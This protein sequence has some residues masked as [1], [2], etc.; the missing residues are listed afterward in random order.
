MKKFRKQNLHIHRFK[1]PSFN[2][3]IIHTNLPSN[4]SGQ[5]TE[6]FYSLSR[7]DRSSLLID[8]HQTPTPNSRRNERDQ[9]PTPQSKR[10][11]LLYPA[12]LPRTSLVTLR[13]PFFILQSF[14]RFYS[15][16]R[17]GRARSRRYREIMHRV[18]VS[19][20]AQLTIPG[21]N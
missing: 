6:K 10:R 18:L 1:L 15:F 8:P 13:S 20:S 11:N 4:L 9:P 2:S 16:G 14:E 17:V 21:I 7:V 12:F 19:S 5:P 3:S